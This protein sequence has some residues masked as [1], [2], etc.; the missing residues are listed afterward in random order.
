M[1]SNELTVSTFINGKNKLEKT[2]EKETVNGNLH[3]LHS[4]AAQGC[5]VASLTEGVAVPLMKWPLSVRV[6][7]FEFGQGPG[8]SSPPLHKGIFNV[9]QLMPAD[10]TPV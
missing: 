2:R 8:D 5:G 9:H 6:G 1:K 7:I 4:C 3:V 10:E